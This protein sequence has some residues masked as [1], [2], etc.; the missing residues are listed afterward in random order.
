MA[1]C[2]NREGVE[3]ILAALAASE[4]ADC[5]IAPGLSDDQ[6][7][8][9]QRKYGFVFPP[10]VRFFYSLGVPLGKG[11][12]PLVPSELPAL[13]QTAN[14]RW[15]NW[16]RLSRPDS[17]KGDANDTVTEQIAF[18][19]T[20][21]GGAH[22]ADTPLIP[23]YAHRMIPAVPCLPG[24]PVFSMH[25]CYDNILYGE[26]FWEWLQREFGVE[27]PREYVVDTRDYKTIPFWCDYIS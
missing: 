10:D 18:H 17:V 1:T 24:N 14:S 15:H 13:Y 5:I 9:I 16:H 26:N 20:P 23:L 25:G 8:A 11:N 27:V 2:W 6:F 22:P 19:A 7:D 21:P 12:S 4:K 3:R